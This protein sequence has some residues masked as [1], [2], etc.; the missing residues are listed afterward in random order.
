MIEQI[1]KLGTEKETKIGEMGRIAA[2]RKTRKDWIERKNLV[3]VPT[4][5]K[6]TSE[7]I[8]DLLE[9]LCCYKS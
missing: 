2:D 1:E 3:D 9:I 6:K 4:S 7:T 5:V 8:F